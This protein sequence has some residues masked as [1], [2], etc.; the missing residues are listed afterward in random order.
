MLQTARV[1]VIDLTSVQSNDAANHSK[2]ATGEV[3]SAIGDRLA[4]G[5]T[6]SDAKPGLVESLG[7][8]TKGAV[9][10]ATDVAVGTVTAPVRLT[11][12]T[13]NEKSVDTAEQ[14]VT[15]DK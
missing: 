5:Q 1:N 15:L 7:G 12:P 8:F 3:V 13:R 9:N 2:F 4:E 6:L 11:D 10:I 14:S